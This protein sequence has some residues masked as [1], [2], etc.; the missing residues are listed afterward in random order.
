MVGWLL[1]SVSARAEAGQTPERY[2]QRLVA[3]T[4]AVRAEIALPRKAA[5][6][7]GDAAVPYDKSIIRQAVRA[8][9]L[10]YQRAG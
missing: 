3:H 7:C 2:F 5:V 4:A 8:R 9:V 10:A 1:R 6:R